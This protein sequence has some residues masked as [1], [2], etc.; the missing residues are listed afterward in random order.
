MQVKGIVIF[1]SHG[2][3]LAARLTC[4]GTDRNTV[5]G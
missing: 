4:V 5:L 3:R 2:V 1:K